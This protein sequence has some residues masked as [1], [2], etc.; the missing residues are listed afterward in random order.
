MCG[1]VDHP[2]P[3]PS[4]LSDITRDLIDKLSLESEA[5][6]EK[7]EACASSLAE[8][9]G[10]LTQLTSM[11][12]NAC[13]ELGINASADKAI[14]SVSP[15]LE[16][17]EMEIAST[18]D[19]INDLTRLM[20]EISDM[21]ERCDRLKK[22]LLA[23]KENASILS[24]NYAEKNTVIRE[25]QAHADS[26]SEKL[27]FESVDDMTAEIKKLTTEADT[28]ILM[29]EN[30]EKQLLESE[31]NYSSLKSALDTLTEQLKDSTASKYSDLEKLCAVLDE[32]IRSVSEEKLALL[33]AVEKNRT[34]SELL[35]NSMAALE[36]AESDAVMYASISDTANGSI[37]GKEKIM[38]E[39]FWQMRLFERILRRASIRLMKMTDGRYELIRRKT[40]SNQRS[41]SGLDLDILDHWNG[42]VRSV[43]SLSG[44]EAF[45]ASLSLALALSD[46]TEAEAG[47][48]K[49]DALFIDEGFG[50]LDEESLTQA[51][52]VLEAQSEGGR[53]VGIISHVEALRERITKKIVV[54]KH[55][56]TSTVKLEGV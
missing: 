13:A 26:L 22:L 48:V 3:A 19:E 55:C 42:S 8:C 40:A 1:S 31:K 18:L 24:A 9:M 17:I 36:S 10:N 47:G 34:I 44:G 51:M 7:A 39:A 15:R 37:N 43:K 33:S 20:A 6:S 2:C 4:S 25:K 45:A 56:G 38:L 41:I 14:I 35:I 28:L 49:I 16:K 54:K 23:E 30:A 32:S 53:S 27:S 52:A 12:E 50:S 46:E 11:I 5:A 29:K 21:S